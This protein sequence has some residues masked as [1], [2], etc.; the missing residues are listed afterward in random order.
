MLLRFGSMS[1]V[2]ALDRFL[3]QSANH[4]NPPSHKDINSWK[5]GRTANE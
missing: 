4:I 1:L 3:F 2:D 5:V